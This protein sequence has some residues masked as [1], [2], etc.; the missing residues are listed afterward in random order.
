MRI[1]ALLLLS[2]LALLTA[3]CNTTETAGGPTAEPLASAPQPVEGYDWFYHVDGDDARLAYG[4][5]ES[6]DLR[7][8]MDCRRGAGRLALSAT[9]QDTGGKDIHIESGGET[10]RFA[11][12][13]EPSQLNDG[14]FLTANAE[15]DAPV[16]LR[17]R[18]V[19]WLA[20][21]QGDMREAYAPHPESR[22]TIERFFAFCG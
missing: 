4:L 3:A 2:A 20:L 18:Q 8:G 10:E 5:A 16:F 17:F 7:L 13:S 14:V 12:V 9:S 1:P 15:A 22:D 19:G 11:A 6:D 21:W